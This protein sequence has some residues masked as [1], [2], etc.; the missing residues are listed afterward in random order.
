MCGKHCNTDYRSYMALQ[1]KL[2]GLSEDF[3]FKPLVTRSGA[4][5]VKEDPELNRQL[6][7]HIVGLDSTTRMHRNQQQ[8]VMDAVLKPIGDP[9]IQQLL[10]HLMD[11]LEKS[12]MSIER[13]S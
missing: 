11:I 1:R 7:L 2:T 10:T 3:K 6:S 5:G 4:Q 8:E 9:N 13:Y 12:G